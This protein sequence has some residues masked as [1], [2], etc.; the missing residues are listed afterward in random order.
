MSSD[1]PFT[2][3]QNRNMDSMAA[4]TRRH[5]DLDTP[6]NCQTFY[7]LMESMKLIWGQGKRRLVDFFHLSVIVFTVMGCTSTS[8]K[9]FSSLM[10]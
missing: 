4:E 9:D 2:V 8:M 5:G 7:H 10:S 1:A 6:S 3:R